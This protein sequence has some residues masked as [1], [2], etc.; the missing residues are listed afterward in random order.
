MIND[1]TIFVSNMI[2]TGQQFQTWLW[3]EHLVMPNRFNETSVDQ[4]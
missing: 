3:R 2:F 1:A 4:A